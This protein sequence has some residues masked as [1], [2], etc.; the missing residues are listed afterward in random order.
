MGGLGT[1]SLQKPGCGIRR[2]IP[3]GN[4]DDQVVS[5]RDTQSITYI[6]GVP[7]N[8]VQSTKAYMIVVVNQNKASSEGSENCLSPRMTCH[9]STLE[10]CNIRGGFR[11]LCK[12]G[13]EF[14]AH[15]SACAKFG[16]LINYS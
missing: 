11:I 2:H 1:Y 9:F 13:P 8:N 14:C 15:I 7:N 16:F 4:C 12:G 6:T 10:F 5:L 3:P